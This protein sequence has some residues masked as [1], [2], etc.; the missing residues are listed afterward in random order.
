MVFAAALASLS[1]VVGAAPAVPTSEN[2][3]APSWASATSAKTFASDVLAAAPL[4]PG[5]RPWQGTTPASLRQPPETTFNPTDLYRFFLVTQ[6]ATSPMMNYVLARLPR[7]TTSSGWGTS[8]APGGGGM[9]QF[10]D[11][12]LPTYGDHE[13]SAQLLFTTARAPAGGFVLRVD[14]QT[15]WEPSRPRSETIPSGYL[16]QLTGFTSVS[17]MNPSSGAISLNPGAATSNELIR[18]F[19]ALPLGPNPVCMEDE[20]LY[21]ITFRP[22]GGPGTAY[23]VEGFACTG[24]VSVAYGAQ[25]LHPLYDRGCS[26]L[27]LVRKLL[28]PKAAGTRGAAAGCAPPTGGGGSAPTRARSSGEQR[29]VEHDAAPRTG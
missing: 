25:Q 7:A 9:S 13:Y 28:P 10:F 11:V 2:R 5:T 26:L 16:A 8:S 1:L 27:R 21:A 17:V 6:T 14:S 23:K 20:E 12:S 29:F 19:D 15:V 18:A 3:A 24:R 4:P 22:S